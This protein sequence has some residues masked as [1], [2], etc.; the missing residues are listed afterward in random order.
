MV[1]STKRNNH[2][3]KKG[4]RKTRQ[5]GGYSPG[6]SRGTFDSIN[7]FYARNTAPPPI[8]HDLYEIARDGNP[9]IHGGL[10]YNDIV[11]APLR[12]NMPIMR[13][14]FH[15]TTGE[16]TTRDE[17]NH[18]LQRSHHRESAF[19]GPDV[20]DEFRGPT[21]VADMMTQ[22]AKFDD[23]EMKQLL[24]DRRD[25]NLSQEEGVL[26]RLGDDVGFGDFT[27]RDGAPTRAVD[28]AGNELGPQTTIT[29][30]TTARDLTAAFRDDFNPYKVV[31]GETLLKSNQ[32]ILDEGAPPIS[33]ELRDDLQ[34]RLDAGTSGDILADLGGN[35]D[36][37]RGYATSEEEN[38]RLGSE[39]D[40]GE[41]DY[42]V[43][44]GATQRYRSENWQEDDTTNGQQGGRKKRKT[45]K[46]KKRKHK[47][48]KR[49]RPRRKTK[50]H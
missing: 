41:Q 2:K 38:Q 22:R 40:R 9:L 19:E 17:N 7:S 15:I 29:R 14:P 47:K 12:E 5:K 43:F 42:D 39:I 27:G 37:Y 28:E 4:G 48:S 44:T 18:V 45:R 32:D 3:K 36:A 34:S 25:A 35:A 16:F 31:D 13:D 11:D 46:H 33:Q 10:I 1:K 49:R 21:D 50:K 8:M 23:A 6:S 20:P 26:E 30:D 24:E